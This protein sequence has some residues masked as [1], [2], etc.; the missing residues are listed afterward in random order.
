[1]KYI[2]NISECHP[3]NGVKGTK[4]EK[5]KPTWKPHEIS[6]LQHQ[7]QLTINVG[8]LKGGRVIEEGGLDE[9]TVLVEDVGVGFV[10]GGDDGG[11]L[12]VLEDL[13]V[14]WGVVHLEGGVGHSGG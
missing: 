1:M 12:G 4:P 14:G 8:R 11:L 7:K 5:R 10:G 9:R 2:W 3:F 6:T 13:V